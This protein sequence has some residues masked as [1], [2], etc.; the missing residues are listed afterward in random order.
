MSSQLKLQ[1]NILNAVRKKN[2]SVTVYLTNGFQLKGKVVGFDNFTII[3]ESDGKNQ[4][5]YKHAV[6]TIVPE[7]RV[8]AFLNNKHKKNNK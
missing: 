6:S 7:E 1:D 2:I 4:L 8:D 5:I 3:L